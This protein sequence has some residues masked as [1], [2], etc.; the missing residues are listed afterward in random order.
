[1]ET[2]NFKRGATCCAFIF[3]PLDMKKIQNKIKYVAAIFSTSCLSNKSPSRGLP[4][5]VRLSI[6]LV[7]GNKIDLVQQQKNIIKFNVV[8]AAGHDPVVY[9]VKNIYR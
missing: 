6:Y 3:K 1:M 2:P 8:E 9:T 5:F 7:Y 4:N